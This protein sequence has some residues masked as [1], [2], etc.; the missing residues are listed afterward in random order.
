[1][2]LIQKPPIGIQLNNNH[3]SASEFVGCWIMN[4]K[5]GGTVFDLSHNDINGINYGAAWVPNGLYLDGASRVDLPKL[6][7]GN[8]DTFTI[9][10][11]VNGAAGGMIY[12]EGAD[13]NTNWAI[14]LGIDA[15]PPYSAWFYYK[16]N[17]VWKALTK[18]TTD[19]NDGWHNVSLVQ[20]N[21]SYR[22]M[23]IDGNL[24][25]VNTDVVGVMSTLNTANIGVLERTS[26]GSYF[27]GTINNVY[28]NK[29]EFSDADVKLYNS[30][31]YTIF[32]QDT[33]LMYYYYDAGWKG[34][35]NG[36]SSANIAKINGIPIA[37]IAKING[38]ASA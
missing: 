7:I 20:R 10:A 37:N 18:G 32:E 27:V 26:F 33:S 14:F 29:C 2:G 13:V 9:S 38:V 6:A 23:Y 21:K 35:I 28:I 17:N 3:P 12:A 31:P 5:T 30:E 22:S 25:D 34:I 16:E 8:R 4:E 11:R 36:I 19:I 24:E 1:M 15:D